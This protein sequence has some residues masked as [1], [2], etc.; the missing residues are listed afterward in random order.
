MTV[1]EIDLQQFGSMV[2]RVETL[3]NQN[4]VLFQKVDK[5]TDAVGKLEVATSAMQTTI[6]THDDDI[7]KLKSWPGRVMDSGCAIV[8]AA[9]A[10][11]TLR[12][13]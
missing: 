2:A 4:E 10:Y 13:H 11:F 7:A 6:K 8:T 3:L 12:G 5:V 1:Q 9:C